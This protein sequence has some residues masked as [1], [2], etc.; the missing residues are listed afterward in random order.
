MNE[1]P[2]H[3]AN[4]IITTF[5]YLVFTLLI[6]WL[7]LGKNP[8]LIKTLLVCGISFIL[9]SAFRHCY[10]APRPYEKDP[11]ISPPKPNCQKG[12]SFPSRHVFCAFLIAVTV[13][14]FY[15]GAGIF[16]LLPAAALAWLRV[17]LHYHS[18]ADVICGGVIGVLC[19][20]IGFWII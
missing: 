12:H 19:A 8:A 17:T 1:K 16:L 13:L 6:L 2:L 14:Y 5:F 11:T 3:I 10:N 9:L 4:Q 7:I 18:A 15:P 20:V